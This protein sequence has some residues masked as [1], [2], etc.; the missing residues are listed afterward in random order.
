MLSTFPA[1]LSFTV[2][3]HCNITPLRAEVIFFSILA[4]QLVAKDKYYIKEGKL[5]TGLGKFCF[6]GK[7]FLHSTYLFLILAEETVAFKAILAHQLLLAF[8]GGH[9]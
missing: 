6:I 4:I 7:E 3:F 2:F 5:L 1:F 8:A 9:Q